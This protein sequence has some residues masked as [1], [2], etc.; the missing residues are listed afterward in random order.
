MHGSRE[1]LGWFLCFFHGQGVTIRITSKENPLSFSIFTS[2]NPFQLH[3][4]QFNLSV[5]TH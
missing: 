1:I 2:K 3:L 5:K 4:R